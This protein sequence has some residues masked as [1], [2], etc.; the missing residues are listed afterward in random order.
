MSRNSFW[1][2][3]RYEGRVETERGMADSGEAVVARV[4]NSV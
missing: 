1:L 4:A 2:R 3:L